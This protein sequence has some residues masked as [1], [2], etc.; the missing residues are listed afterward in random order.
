MLLDTSRPEISARVGPRATSLLVLYGMTGFS[1]LIAE[2]VLEKYVTLLVGVTAAA[3]AVILF[4][5]FLGF[6]VGGLAAGGLLKR[7]FVQNPL[8]AYAGIELLTGCACVVFSFG[9][10][11]A[12]AALAP[13]QNLV[14]GEFGKYLVRFLC[15]CILVLPVAG[16]MGA[17]FPLLAQALDN[18]DGNA[19]KRWSVA[20]SANLAGAV[21]A[22]LAA[23]FVLLPAIGLRGAM[24]LC[25]AICAAVALFVQVRGGEAVPARPGSS[26][27]PRGG[28]WQPEYAFLVIASCL[29]GCVF[30]ALE[31]IWVH[32]VGAVVGGSVYAFSW[33]LTSVLI[34]LWAGSWAANRSNG[35]RPAK[36]FLLCAFT[37]L[38]Q[39]SAWPLAPALFVLAPA[40]VPTGFY[41]RELY[42]LL[43][44]CLL[45]VPPACSLGLI[46]PTLLKAPRPG[47]QESAWFAGYLSAANSIGCLAGALLSTF[48]LVDRLGSELSLK[49]I[50]LMLGALWLFFDFREPNKGLRSRLVT[51]VMA[52][53]LVWGVVATTWNWAYLTSGASM[54]FGENAGAWATPSTTGPAPAVSNGIVFRDESIA[55]G[56]TTVVESRTDSGTST[57][58][59]TFNLFTNGKLQGND[60][61]TGLVQAQ[62][63]GTALLPSLFTKHFNGA[64]LIGLGTGHGAAVLK[65]LGFE[66]LDIAELS[67]G[68]VRA[69][70][71]EFRHTN[72]GVLDDPTVHCTLEDGRNLL[73]TKVDAR[74]DL[75]TVGLTTI[76]FSGATNLYSQE[77]YRLARQHLAEDGVLQQWVQL[78]R[79]GPDEIGSAIASVRSVFPYVSY[80]NYD[81]AGMVLAANHPLELKAAQHEHLAS[82]L[83]RHGGLPLKDAQDLMDRILHSRLL[84]EQAVDRL[85]LERHPIINTD[86]NRH[87]EYASPRYSSSDRD[88][89]KYNLEFL[90]QWDQQSQAAPVATK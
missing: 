21:L 69:V 64:L 71:A 2:Q 26:A 77:F 90:K 70:N 6:A 45:I 78:H 50:T 39:L 75:I 49:L 48:V 47:R 7:G 89:A 17:S 81:G 19:P 67:P 46:Y 36:V 80:W 54:Y 68:I 31:I 63:V 82:M 8:R 57:R 42:R 25:L 44:A 86:Q 87:I 85:I 13:L 83:S 38:F 73:L 52:G 60:D 61:Q 79:I 1:G 40:W 5:Y 55:G 66:R 4:T 74:Y 34:G 20:Y 12:M 18:A 53:M 10:P 56:F 15:G 41:T 28:N 22:S 35:I 3:S 59:V 30:F 58:K 33:M 27:A 32:L 76:W 72:H 88:W 65:Q 16:L 24:W 23:P 37:L 29:S 84:S 9:F 51:A 62:Q 14:A 11:A 43:V